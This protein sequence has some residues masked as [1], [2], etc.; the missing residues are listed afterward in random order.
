[1]LDIKQDTVKVQQEV[2]I[3]PIG[4]KEVIRLDSEPL[5]GSDHLNEK[6]MLALSKQKK[7]SSSLNKI[8]TLLNK[9]V[10]I[11]A[12]LDKGILKFIG[13]R[14]FGPAAIKSLAGFFN[15]E[16]ENVVILISN[17]ANI[18][19]YVSNRFLANLTCHELTHRAAYLDANK[20]Y[21]TFKP[22]LIVWYRYLF[23]DIFK[24]DK[25]QLNDNIVFSVVKFLFQN[26]E[27]KVGGASSGDLIKYS[28]L[29][30]E[31]L[32]SLTSLKHDEFKTLA[33]DY[34]QIVAIYLKS[35]NYFFD[36]MGEFSHILY[37]MYRA[38][39]KGL[40]VR[41]NSTVC[42]QELIY[43]SEIICVLSEFGKDNVASRVLSLN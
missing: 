36:S 17:N 13:W 27:M 41:N 9:K 4:L 24:I 40:N 29:I 18:F 5:Y 2:F 30:K 35:L 20:F 22:E 7:T 28:K 11:P 25:N 23:S 37:P 33:D 34:I 32:V 15:P 10:I 31:Q 16:L 38:Y 12:F 42:I 1:M 39:K 8:E 6:F 43:P 26:I 21:H 19:T 14:I 3:A